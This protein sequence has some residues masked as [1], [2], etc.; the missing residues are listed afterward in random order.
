[1]PKPLLLA[2]STTTHRTVLLHPLVTLVVSRPRVGFYSYLVGE[3]M[4]E[5]KAW[6]HVKLPALE[7]SGDLKKLCVA[8]HKR[9]S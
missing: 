7:V 6:Q 8:Q 1:M 4:D 9:L 2:P 3:L 5:Q